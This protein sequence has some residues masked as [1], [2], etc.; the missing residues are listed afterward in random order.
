MQGKASGLGQAREQA[1]V[2]KGSLV[3][4]VGFRLGGLEAGLCWMVGLGVSGSVR[5]VRWVRAQTELEVSI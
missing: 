1:G 3:G 2:R 5:V 4:W